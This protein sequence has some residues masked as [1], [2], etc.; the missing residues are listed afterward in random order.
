MSNEEL[1]AALAEL[2]QELAKLNAASVATNE[3]TKIIGS[4]AGK[5][6]RPGKVDPSR[7]YVLLTKE[8]SK[9]GRVPQQQIDIAAIIA[10]HFEIGQVISEA[11][12]FAAVT[13]DAH[14]YPQLANSVQD[15]TYL[16]RYYRGLRNDGKYAGFIARGFIR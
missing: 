2:K 3:E 8:L 16:F 15:P 6:H 11:D 7:K 5:N 9:W 1:A 14:K 13:A 12:L 4:T 10:E